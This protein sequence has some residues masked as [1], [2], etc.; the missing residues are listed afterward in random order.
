MKIPILMAPDWQIV[1]AHHARLRAERAGTGSGRTY[2][3]NA[4]CS[5][6]FGNTAQSSSATVVVPKNQ[7]K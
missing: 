4:T 2:T 5:D 7:T 1:D 6:R 3:V